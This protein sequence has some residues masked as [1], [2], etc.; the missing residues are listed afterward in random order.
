M[1]VRNYVCMSVNVYVLY[2]NMYVSMYVCMYVLNVL[3]VC[4]HY[5]NLRSFFTFHSLEL[6][7]LFLQLFHLAQHTSN[8]SILG[9]TCMYVCMYVCM[10]MCM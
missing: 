10:Y 3:Y 7:Q 1:Y 9:I 5:L 8:L 6:L 4:C 2:V